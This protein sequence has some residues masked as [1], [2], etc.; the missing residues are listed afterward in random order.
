[1]TATASA[2]QSLTMLDTIFDSSD[3]VKSVRSLA[4]SSLYKIGI[5]ADRA[6]IGAVSFGLF[7]GLAFAFEYV[8]LG[9][10]MLLVSALLD[11][12]DGTVAREHASATPLGGLMDL[13]FD[14]IVEAAVILGIT[15]RR[16]ELHLPALVLV[17]TWY[18]NITIFLAVGA[19]LDRRGPK[20]IDYPPGLLERTEAIIFFILLAFSGSFGPALCYLFAM[21]EV[22]TGAQRFIFGFEHLAPA[23]PKAV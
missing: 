16:P 5:T 11:G 13:S 8:R 3:A 9:T 18:V 20:L 4:A 15:L 10:A 7:A 12:L 1:L 22:Y 6:S 23:D 19:A 21:L 14:R 2:R 17:T